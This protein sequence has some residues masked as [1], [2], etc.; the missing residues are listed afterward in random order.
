MSLPLTFHPEV[1]DEID[2]AYRWH[3][4][5]RVP[6]G[7]DFLA[8][9]DEVYRRIGQMPLIHQVIWQDVRRALPRKFSYGVFYCVYADRVE[10]IAVQHTSRD[11]A[12]W[13]SRV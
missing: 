2:E 1:Q 8:A 6:R 3:E 9:L 7:D 11:P 13:Q 4:R 12:R 10:V 5:Q